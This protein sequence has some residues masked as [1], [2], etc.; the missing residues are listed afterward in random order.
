MTFTNTCYF[1]NT[2]FLNVSLKVAASE[3]NETKGKD[4]FFNNF[5][6][7]KFSEF[8]LIFFTPAL[9]SNT[10]EFMPHDSFLSHAS[11]QHARSMMFCTIFK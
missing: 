11:R 3:I 2:A 1:Q 10:K 7:K 9:N 6:Q 5:Q 8:N 4:S